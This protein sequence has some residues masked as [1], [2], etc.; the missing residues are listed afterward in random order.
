MLLWARPHTKLFTQ[1]ITRV[2]PTSLAWKYYTITITILILHMR[3]MRLRLVKAPAQ[4]L[5]VT[6]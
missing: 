5:V 6:E 1:I 4:G 3:Q 2:F